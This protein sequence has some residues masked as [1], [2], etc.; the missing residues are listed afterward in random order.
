MVEEG[1]MNTART[2]AMEVFQCKDDLGG[3]EPAKQCAHKTVHVKTTTTYCK[4][5]G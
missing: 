5:T 1:E 3:I 2:H 4:K